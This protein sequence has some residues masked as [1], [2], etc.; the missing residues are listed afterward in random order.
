MPFAFLPYPF[1]PDFSDYPFPGSQYTVD[2]PAN[3]FFSSTYGINIDNAY[4]YRDSRDTF[5]GI[6]VSVGEVSEIASTQTG[7]VTFLDT[8]DF[9]TIDW[10]SIQPTTYRVFS[11]IGTQLGSTL[12]VGSNQTGTESFGGGGTAIAY[13]EWT[14][15]GGFGQISGLSYNYDGLTDGRNDD[16]PTSVP[17]PA[18]LSLIGMSL[19]GLRFV[20]RGR[21]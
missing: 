15:Q 14:G 13:L 6:G 10:W 17:E 16:L 1:T 19:F 9:V 5:D 3:A 4:L 11:G 7:R 21:S 12:S 2:A 18:T 20:R 8:T